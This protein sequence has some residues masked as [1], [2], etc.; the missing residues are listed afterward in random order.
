MKKA[1]WLAVAIAAAIGAF[2]ASESAFAESV[3]RA[4]PLLDVKIL[5]PYQN[6]NYGTR[7]HGH[8]IYETLFAWDS[9]QQ[10]KPDM[11]GDYSVSADKLTYR[12]TLRPGLKW[13]DGKP[14][15]AADCVASLEK[16]M[17]KDELGMRLARAMASLKADDD[18]SFTLT[19]KE[20][21]GLVLDALAKPSNYA[22][23][24]IPERF[25]RLPEGSPDFQ[26]IGSGP[27]IFKKDEWQPGIKNV[28]VRNPDYV[29]RQEP[30]DGMAGGKVVKVDRVEWIT[31]PDA[32]TAANALLTGEV[33]RIENVSFDVIGQLEGDG[34]I[35]I[36]P[37]DPLGT[38]Q[39]LRPNHL[40]PPFNNVKARQALLYI[41][42]QDLY[43]KAIAGDKR[44]YRNCPAYLMC[45]A[46]YG[47]TAGAVKPDLDKA[48]AL[49]KEAGYN[50]EKV[51]MLEPTNTPQFDAPTQVTASQ[52][53]KIGVNVEL[54]P[55][56]YNAMIARRTKRDPI[57]Q[58]GWNLYHSGNQAVDVA[59]PM[60]NI[61]LAASCDKASPGWPCDEEIES[62]KDAFAR[63]SDMAERK[64][65]AEKIQRRAMEV[66]PYAVVVQAW[67]VTAYRKS[68][69]NVLQSPIA[70]YW[71]LEKKS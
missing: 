2:V 35:V 27:F 31:M 13:H 25:A 29:P 70:L 23:F 69:T 5:D 19:L 32:N 24:I 21:F 68:L 37:S 41:L 6:T 18:K 45:D 15:T 52:L 46:P 17:T 22:P 42:D 64:A 53:R 3:V 9:H 34:N 33:D 63:T 11:V 66:V 8:M 39:Y 16:W 14:V 1:R 20:P 71:N 28:Y 48:R 12:F 55:M 49:M 62:L 4:V 40:Y 50:G 60:T 67:I 43:G 7:N 47:S 36:G 26:P 59:S 57:D 56:D 30:P 54:Q 58:G 38:Q 65:I 44:F 10:P 51:V 61:Y